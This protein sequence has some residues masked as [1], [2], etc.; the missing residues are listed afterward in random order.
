MLAFGH[1]V[2]MCIGHHVAKM[3]ARVGLQE[4]MRR[5]PEYELDMSRARR[6]R[7]EFVQGW[8]ELPAE[9]RPS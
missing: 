8:T 2:H 7:T 1:G 3:E 5:V 9:L 4:L 6:L